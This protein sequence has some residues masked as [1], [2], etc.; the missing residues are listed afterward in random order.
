[1]KLLDLKQKI[2]NKIVPD[3]F[4]VFLCSENDFLAEQY[5]EAVALNRGLTINRIESLD[6]LD[7]ANALVLDFESQL[8]ILKV[9]TFEEVRPDYSKYETVL[10][11][12]NKIDKKIKPLL[13][14]FII[15]IPK[16]LEWQTKAYIKTLC[17]EL[18]E[19]QIDILYKMTGGDVYRITT[20]LDKITIFAAPQRQKIFNQ[21]I[22]DD[23][24]DLYK[25]E[26]YTLVDYI[27]KNDRGSV[28][29]FVKH[30]KFMD[31]NP[32]GLVTL[33]L[34]KYLQILYVRQ[35]SGLESYKQVGMEP[36]QANAIK[37]YYSGIML[38]RLMQ[39]IQFLSGLD[40]KIKLGQLD[41]NNDQLLDY[42][43]CHTLF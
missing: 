19:G 20:E 42:I 31:V 9:D 41:M 16:L 10:I 33:L 39:A 5:A 17:P 12:C 38:E 15:E 4:M 22:F 34:K 8:N 11:I 35:D 43:L 24:S 6:E 32:F 26:T 30:K 25:I 28:L 23:S 13:N 18:N 14:E 1:M 2:K 40:S 36:K 21:I 3:T 27:V 7:S 29:N 37:K